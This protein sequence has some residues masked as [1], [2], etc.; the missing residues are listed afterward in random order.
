MPR[1][2]AILIMHTKS[3]LLE[4]W[5]NYLVSNTLL[6]A[7]QASTDVFAGPLANQT[8]LAIKGIIGIKAM[9]VI[10]GMLGDTAMQA[11]L[12]VSISQIQGHAS[13]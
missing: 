13:I 4:Q 10:A 3:K 8:N 1:L 12:T 6:P 7:N 5:A 11:N 2:N 9:S